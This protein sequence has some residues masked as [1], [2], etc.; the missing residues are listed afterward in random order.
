MSGGKEYWSPIVTFTTVHT[1]SYRTTVIAPTCTAKGYTTHTC[2]CGDSYVDTYTNALGHAWDGGTVT[3][4]PTATETGVRTYTCT[5][6]NET[7]TESSR[8]SAST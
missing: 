5:R 6:C 7:K 3:K 1:H 2:S 8:S 4:Q